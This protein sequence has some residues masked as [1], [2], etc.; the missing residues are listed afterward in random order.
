M[1]ATYYQNG[2][3][4]DYTP[5]GA[6]VTAG[7]VVVR[8]DTVCIARHPIAD[9]V[10]GSLCCQGTFKDCV[11]ANDEAFSQGD[12]LYYNSSTPKFTKVGT[13]NK[14]AGIAALAAAETAVV[15]H[16]RLSPGDPGATS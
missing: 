4:L 8:G 6:A 10:K 9:G 7:Q 13:D 5:S 14:Y 11:K 2:D 16:V 15:C 1:P 12:R 3:E